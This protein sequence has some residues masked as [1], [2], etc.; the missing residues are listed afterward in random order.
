VPSS[1]VPSSHFSNNP[2]ENLKP[3]Y[4]TIAPHPHVARDK[5]VSYL[6]CSPESTTA[7]I[8]RTPQIGKTVNK[9]HKKLRIVALQVFHSFLVPV[10]II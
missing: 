9:H 6:I 1:H 4:N 2:S 8:A 10:V 5:M 7:A 3:E